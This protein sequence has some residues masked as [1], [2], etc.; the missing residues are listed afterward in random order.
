MSI[1]GAGPGDTTTMREAH[2]TTSINDKRERKKYNVRRRWG[3]ASK[4]PINSKRERKSLILK[5]DEE[6]QLKVIREKWGWE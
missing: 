5:G 2:V 6:K 1:L 4:N 3:K